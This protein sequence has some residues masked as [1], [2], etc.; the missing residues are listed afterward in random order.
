MFN[1]SLQ[2]CHITLTS[3]LRLTVS[4]F[5][6][7]IETRPSALAYT[8]AARTEQLQ[9]ETD[10]P[11]LPSV[12]MLSHNNLNHCR[13]TSLPDVF[14]LVFEKNPLSTPTDFK[15]EVQLLPLMLHYH[16]AAA[17][18]FF[19]FLLLP[20]MDALEVTW[21]F[22]HQTYKYATQFSRFIR[23]CLTSRVLCDVHVNLANPTIM[24]G[25]YGQMA[26][27]GS[28]LVLDCG[29]LLI[30]SAMVEEMS[31]PGNLS[32]EEIQQKIY[33]KFLFTF[34][35]VQL[36]LLP[37]GVSWS[38]VSDE[39]SSEHHLV[40]KTKMKVTLSTSVLQLQE[41]PAWKIEAFVKCAKLSLSDSKLSSM[42]D[43]LRD[44]PLPSRSKNMHSPRGRGTRWRFLKFFGHQC[45]S[46]VPIVEN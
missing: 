36:V 12:T 10:M 6:V 43:F 34:S 17:S 2:Q 7:C 33:D 42:I 37:Q 45:R 21:G 27:G 22:I 11:D 1:F 35:G 23:N 13:D 41:V 32:P 5:N 14:K 39:P 44:L 38:S 3:I 15:L 24:I 18:E 26:N 29:Q 25:Q 20:T 16:E 28:N 8:V 30:E 46:Q 9:V 19:D 40:P 4:N 31:E